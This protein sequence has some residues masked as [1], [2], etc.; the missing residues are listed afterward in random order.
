MANEKRVIDAN[1]LMDTI[2]QHEYSLA[3]KQGSVD[4]GMFTAGIQQAVDEQP[5]VD[6]IPAAHSKWACVNEDEN[7]WMCD[8]IEG[9]GGEMIILEKTPLENGFHFCP[10]CGADMRGDSHG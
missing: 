3:T 5:T 1:A 10:Y 6:A 8:G 2:R 4:Y 7:V 9:C